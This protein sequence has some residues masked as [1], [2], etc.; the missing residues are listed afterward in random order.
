MSKSQ[1]RRKWS[2]ADLRKE[3]DNG[4]RSPFYFLYGDEDF[5][6]DTTCTWLKEALAPTVAPEF[7]VDVFHG[8]TFVLEDFLKIYQS[9]PMMAPH[10]LVVL[11]G[12]EKFSIGTCKELESVV[13]SPADTTLLIAVGGKV[14]KRRKFFEQLARKGRAVEFRVPYDNQLPQWIQG[15]ASRQALR[16]DPD[17]ADL[18]RLYVGSNLRE[19]AGEIDKLGTFVGEERRITRDDVE[20]VVGVS[21]STSIFDF[22]DAIGCQNH[23]K[24]LELLHRLIEEGEESGRILAMICRHFRLLLKARTLLKSSL[25]REQL[26]AQL[27]VAPFFL[28]AYL[29]QARHY[30]LRSLWDGLGA[31]LEADVHL[32]SKGRKQERV[33]MDLLVHRLCAR[34]RQ[35]GVDRRGHAVY[36]DA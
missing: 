36:I 2:A 1:T 6:R 24:A 31:L 23:S 19:L 35:D 11:R 5:E 27:G 4:K 13:E 12:C 26:A 34:P 21:R 14:D 32:K 8:D 28:Q 25:P 10:R 3:L 15:Y 30:P 33:I 20:Q 7:N 29:D 9:Y 18:L 22:T 16:I 17:A